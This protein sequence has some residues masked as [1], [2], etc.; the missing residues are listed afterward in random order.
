MKEMV[1]CGGQETIFIHL[2]MQV[3]NQISARMK[4]KRTK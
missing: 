1:F 3:I 2:F 4:G